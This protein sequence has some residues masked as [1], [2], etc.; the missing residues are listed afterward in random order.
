MLARFIYGFRISVIF[1]LTL[2]IVSTVLGTIAGGTQGYFGGR[3]DLF[4]Q[5][6][7]EIWSGLPMLYLLIILASLVEPSFWWLLG[8]M[9]LFHG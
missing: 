8:L 4:F 3:Y 6:F 7:I 2:T 9:L 5:R 1:G